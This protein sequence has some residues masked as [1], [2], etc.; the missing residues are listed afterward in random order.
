MDTLKLLNNMISK[1]ID[2]SVLKKAGMIDSVVPLHNFYEL[3][4]NPIKPWLDNDVDGHN[5]FCLKSPSLFNKSQPKNIL[6]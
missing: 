2:F 3:N 6:D 4:E 1:N 5:E